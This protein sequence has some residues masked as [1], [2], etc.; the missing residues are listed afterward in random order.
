MLR[1]V[2]PA[3]KGEENITASML[4]PGGDVEVGVTPWERVWG[5][6]VGLSCRGLRSP[7]RGMMEHQVE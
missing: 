3:A 5:G 7:Y 1:T 4:V 2:D 6:R